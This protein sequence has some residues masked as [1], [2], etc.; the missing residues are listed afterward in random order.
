[1]NN[2]LL[3]KRNVAG[4]LLGLFVMA[5]QPAQAAY[6]CEGMEAGQ[7]TD[8][9]GTIL[10]QPSGKIFVRKGS[11]YLVEVK[12]NSEGV[13]MTSFV[14]LREGLYQKLAKCRVGASTEVAFRVRC[15]ARGEPEVIQVVC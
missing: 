3:E 4:I 1:M 11:N 12:G 9:V 7:K 15:T 10:V 5:V 6:L 2:N 8:I 14:A 13:A